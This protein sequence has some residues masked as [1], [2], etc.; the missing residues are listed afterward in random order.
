MLAGQLKEARARFDALLRDEI[1]AF[2][3]SRGERGVP[4]IVVR[5]P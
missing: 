4:G 2:N 3:R 5:A 1:P